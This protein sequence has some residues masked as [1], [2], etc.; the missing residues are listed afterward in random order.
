M[1]LSTKPMS[2]LHNNYTVYTSSTLNESLSNLTSPLGRKWYDNVFTLYGNC[3][4]NIVL[5]GPDSAPIQGYGIDCS[6]EY[7]YV[8]CT[9]NHGSQKSTVLFIPAYEIKYIHR[10][11]YDKHNN[12]VFGG[13]GI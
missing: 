6:P 3:I 11:P 2:S 13:G 7:V 12:Y 9:E 4:L 5:D 8:L 10:G 1:V